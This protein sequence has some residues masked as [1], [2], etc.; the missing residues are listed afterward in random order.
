MITNQ[1]LMEKVDDFYN[2][3]LQIYL[4]RIEK[5]NKKIEDKRKEIEELIGKK[6]IL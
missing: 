2:D 5:N 3:L 1:E 6:G 4:A